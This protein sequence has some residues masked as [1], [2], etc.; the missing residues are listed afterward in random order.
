MRFFN[1]CENT[2]QLEK[3]AGENK[4]ISVPEERAG[5]LQ[6]PEWQLGEM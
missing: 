6:S 4:Q 1:T 2:L 3:G 5:H